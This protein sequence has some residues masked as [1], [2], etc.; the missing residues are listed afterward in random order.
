MSRTKHT[1]NPAKPHWTQLASAEVRER[2]RLK[3][4]VHDLTRALETT[5]NAL[6][7]ALDLIDKYGGDAPNKL[8]LP[9]RDTAAYGRKILEGE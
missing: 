4:R 2:A 9:L 1:Q 8:V 7:A 5:S 6:D 3:V